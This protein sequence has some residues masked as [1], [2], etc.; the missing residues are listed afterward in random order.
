MRRPIR[1]PMRPRRTAWMSPSKRAS[2]YRKPR[3]VTATESYCPSPRG[4]PPPRR[5]AQATIP[6]ACVAFRGTSLTRRRQRSLR[7]RGAPRDARGEPLRS[8]PPRLASGNPPSRQSPNADRRRAGSSRDSR[9]QDRDGAREALLALR[10]SP[11]RRARRPRRA[12]GGLREPGG[13][14]DCSAEVHE[15]PECSRP[16]PK[17]DCRCINS[18][19]KVRGSRSSPKFLRQ[20]EF[21]TTGTPYWSLGSAPADQCRSIIS[22]KH[23]QR[24]RAALAGASHTGSLR[25]FA[26]TGRRRDR[27]GRPSLRA[28]AG[29]YTLRQ[30]RRRPGS[31]IPP[32]RP[33][34][35][36]AEPRAAVACYAP[37]CSRCSRPEGGSRNRSSRFLE[38]SR[39]LHPAA[40]GFRPA[41]GIQWQGQES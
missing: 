10:K 31:A 23:A 37:G 7:A 16:L 25:N 24:G 12:S 41:G 17:K 1:G 35:N 2:Q 38:V 39:R 8:E 29:S 26:G 22:I 15:R 19:A 27:S 33:R 18:A 32:S 11:R 21:R 6:G 14:G 34:E 4:A 30:T 13:G 20:S 9:A 5:P 3:N 40:T 28:R 36:D